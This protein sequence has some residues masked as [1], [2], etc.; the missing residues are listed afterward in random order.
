MVP[1]LSWSEEGKSTG[2]SADHMRDSTSF[3]L[4]E[5]PKVERYRG[6]FRSF[7]IDD[8]GVKMGAT[9]KG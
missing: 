1:N 4:Y 9:M 3:I 5:Q 2:M 6:V 7:I 8:Q